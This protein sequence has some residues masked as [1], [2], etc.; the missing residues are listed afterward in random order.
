[1]AVLLTWPLTARLATHLPTGTDTLSHYWNNWATLEALRSGHSPYFTPY[2]FYPTGVS[3]VYKNYAW[4]HILAWLAL[5]PLVGGIAA[6]NVAFLAGLAL[7]GCAAFV[8]VRELTGDWR[9][10]FVAGVI[11]QGWPY[12]MT[13]PS[14]PNLISTGAIPLFVLFWGRTLR[15]GR[16]QD[17]LLTGLFL[18]LIGYTRWQLLI[19]AAMIGVVYGLWNLPRRSS[20]NL[21]LAVG[22]AGLIASLA[23]AP[24][25]LLLVREMR[26]M[27]ASLT[28]DDE[29]SIMQ[30]DLLAYLTPPSAHRALGAWTE[31]LYQRYY[32]GRGSRFVHSPYIGLSAVL[33]TL[34]GVTRLRL[35]RSLPWVVLGML[36]LLL[37]L[38]PELRLNG[39][40]YPHVPMFYDLAARVPGI[41][42]MRVPER[43]N[44]FLA[45][46]VAVL[47]GYGA[48][49]VLSD[50]VVARVSALPQR[51]GLGR[52]SERKGAGAALLAALIA[53]AIVFEYLVLP[54]PL[55]A[56]RVAAFYTQ[57][58]LEPGSGAVLNVPVD[59]Y[60]SKPYMYAQTVHQRPIVQGRV[61]RYPEGVFD[62]LES[63]PW[64]R[65]MRRYKEVPPR[66]P[67]V[68][69]Q[70]RAL[71]EDGI[72]YVI[73]HKS[74]IGD[75]NWA[76]WA[77][78]LALEP[79]FED[80]EIAVFSTTPLAG[81]DL[82][83][84]SE[85]IP[86]LGVVHAIPS[87]RCVRPG[88]A[89][90]LDVAWGTTAP[91]GKDL[92]V[93]LALVA[94]DGTAFD[95]GTFPI[96]PEWPSHEW[97]ANTVVWGHYSTEIFSELPVGA[98]DLRLGL[99]EAETGLVLGQPAD[100]DQL[101]VRA[102]ACIYPVPGDAVEMNARFGDAMRLLGYRVD[103]AD[104]RVELTLI[105]RPE[106]QMRTSY[107]VFVHVYDLGTGIPV[108][109]DDAVPLR[110]TY[111]TTYWRLG[112]VVTDVIAISMEAAP[113]GEYGL[114][115]GVYDPGSGDRLSV[116]DRSDQAQP[117]DRLVLP[118]EIVEVH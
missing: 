82:R 32:A 40:L 42:W 118:G 67:D 96:S 97:P 74:L 37:A 34:V 16:W 23:L 66:Q 10:G 111:P 63:Q 102:S 7:C 47:A 44:M 41:R 17:G 75:A 90:E 83:L 2:L 27:P 104:D 61:S 88:R 24:P 19:P 20:R 81:Q 51:L 99:S 84:A 101:E 108:A 30:T 68:G 11:Y 4:L 49:H 6:Y 116:R 35:R 89:F 25:A 31:P 78:Y 115:L 117:D 56:A 76:R 62:Y 93:D 46:P 13:Q 33:L 107:K 8:L 1:L 71:A 98:Y 43:F 22:L 77:R 21:V 38:G 91:P 53:G 15:R 94:P 9:A 103:R 45:L 70:L 106:R 69:R 64:I 73:V 36:F 28:V 109:Q 54:L 86:G 29:E 100:I 50:G 105:W 48:V 59:P 65:E 12:R 85:P 55:Q 87:A 95:A 113:L 52:R 26:R 39:R 60:A 58:A 5:R 114:A 57:L 79:R 80:D 14:H 3:T 112:E 72:H 92:A 18:S 110:W